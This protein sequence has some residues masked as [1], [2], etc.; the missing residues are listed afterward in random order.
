MLPS[1]STVSGDNQEIDF[2]N[3]VLIWITTLKD[4]HLQPN[5]CGRDTLACRVW[6]IKFSIAHS[7]IKMI[8]CD[9]HQNLSLGA[10]GRD[11]PLGPSTLFLPPTSNQVIYSLS[12]FTFWRDQEILDRL[13][14]A[15]HTSNWKESYTW[16]FQTAKSLWWQMPARTGNHG[17]LEMKVDDI[18][19]QSSMDW[20]PYSSKSLDLYC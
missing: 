15:G 4:V 13:L 8:K 11:G 17:L 16:S 19:W 12:Q 18:V 10:E 5:T 1:Q 9:W 20:I 6:R 2:K 7:T 14:S 3:T